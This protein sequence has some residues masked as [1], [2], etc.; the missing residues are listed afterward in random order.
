MSR[1]PSV[2]DGDRSRVESGKQSN[3]K[4]RLRGYS[5]NKKSYIEDEGYRPR[6]SKPRRKKV[7]RS[8]RDDS[9]ERSRRM[10][11]QE[12]YPRRQ[13]EEQRHRNNYQ[14]RQ[15]NSVPKS[16]GILIF[17]FLSNLIFYGVTIG[18]IVM[19][20]MFSFSSKSSA[21]IFGY[22]FYTVLTNSMVPQEDGP[23]GG[24]YAG[25]IVIVKLTDGNK[26]KKDD[27]I[28][29]AVGDGSRYLTHR[30]VERKDELNGEKGDYLITKGDANKTNDPPIK[31]D[32]V[33]G[34]VVFI[35][36]KVGDV[37]EFVRAEFWACF[38]CILSLYGFFLVLKSYLFTPKEETIR[39]RNTRYPLYER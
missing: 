32:R 4:K 8:S 21:S 9:Y 20:V 3:P 39:R 25:D 34:K 26:V 1:K 13:I 14:R 28:T 7:T 29:F 16:P 19:A 15:D 31:A 37:L 35:V 38:V 24:F 33:L 5:D 30:M 2:R 23:K 12:A 17:S 27:V 36:P 6:T 18:I 10:A 11:Y 22:R